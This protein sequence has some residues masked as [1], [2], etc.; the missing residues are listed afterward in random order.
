MSLPLPEAR[1]SAFEKMGFGMFIHWGL[2]SQLG[3]GEWAQASQSIPF[4]EYKKLAD[5]F[6]AADFDADAIAALA[7]KAGMKYIVLTTRHHDGFSLY[8]TCQR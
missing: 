1:I 3:A 7:A 4:C 6:T 2:Y 5:T 8:D